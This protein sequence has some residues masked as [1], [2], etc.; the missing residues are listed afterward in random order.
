MS[1][2]KE[3]LMMYV[4]IKL[5]PHSNAE[6]RVSQ[7]IKVIQHRTHKLRFWNLITKFVYSIT[8]L[9]PVGERKFN[10][11]KSRRSHKWSN[12]QLNG[13]PMT[14]HYLKY[15]ICIVQFI[16]VLQQV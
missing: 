4:N 12:N 3:M 6:G 16:Q 8:H 9:S 7:Y 5:V 1:H 14:R 10:L 15:N 2:F 13:P 11:I